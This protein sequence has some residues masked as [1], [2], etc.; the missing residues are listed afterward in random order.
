M[1]VS[2]I[3]VALK[4]RLIAIVN[5]TSKL[6]IIYGH[7]VLLSEYQ[8]SLLPLA[9]PSTA[10]IHPHWWHIASTVAYSES[11]LYCSTLGGAFDHSY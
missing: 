11:L 5:L 8:M 10:T 2:A 9:S 6:E 3:T 7:S 1:I 4:T